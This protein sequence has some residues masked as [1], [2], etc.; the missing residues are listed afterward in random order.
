MP[1]QGCS[2][3]SQPHTC[4]SPLRFPETSDQQSNASLHF[5]PHCVSQVF[6][7]SKGKGLSRLGGVFFC[8]FL[9]N[10]LPFANQLPVSLTE[11]REEEFSTPRTSSSFS[12][13]PI[14]CLS[15]RIQSLSGAPRGPHCR[16]GSSP[17]PVS[18]PLLFQRKNCRV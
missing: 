2:S 6:T 12:S 8:S 3:L 18:F 15:S 1:E 11:G 10:H 17:D 16:D 14:L 5:M 7:F 9:G 13:S 4:S